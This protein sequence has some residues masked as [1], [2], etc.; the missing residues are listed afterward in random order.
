M[1]S[2]I[3]TKYFV[4]HLTRL[5]VTNCGGGGRKMDSDDNMQHL[6]LLSCTHGHWVTVAPV[7]C[8]QCLVVQDT[9]EVKFV[10]NDSVSGMVDNNRN[11]D[12]DLPLVNPPTEDQVTESR[13][14][15]LK[16]WE[17]RIHK[18]CKP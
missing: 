1:P 2:V 16:A 14:E 3:V 12:F 8:R 10:V 7:L 5:Y 9:F 4:N 11:K 6:S 17:L 13:T 15:R 18:V